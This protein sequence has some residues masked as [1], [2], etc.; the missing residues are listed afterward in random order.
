MTP[1][2]PPDA[3]ALRCRCERCGRALPAI[4]A[5]CEA[6]ET[7]LSAPAVDHAHGPYR[8]PA[9]ERPFKRP[10]FTLVPAQAR[11]YVPQSQ[12]LACPHCRA[13]LLDRLNPKMPA[14]EAFALMA[15]AVAAQ[16]MLPIRHT[17]IA[18]MVLVLVYLGLQLY[19]RAWGLPKDQRYARAPS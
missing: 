15:L 8:C 10:D 12:A 9:C 13:L 5:V 1:T 16:F 18:M 14:R 3:A 7:E 19:R 11:W 6:C 17:R 2:P 4:D